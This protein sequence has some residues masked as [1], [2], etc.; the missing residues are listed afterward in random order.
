MRFLVGW[1]SVAPQNQNFTRSRLDE[2]SVPGEAYLCML[3]LIDCHGATSHAS[4]LVSCCPPYARTSS[5]DPGVAG[6]LIEASD[7]RS[8]A[9]IACVRQGNHLGRIARPKEYLIEFDDQIDQAAAVA[10]LG[11]LQARV[12]HRLDAKT[13]VVAVQRSRVALPD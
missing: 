11:E 1:L 3:A 9:V 6:G 2:R 10:M 5:N 13:I 7:G 12:M 4:A 8:G